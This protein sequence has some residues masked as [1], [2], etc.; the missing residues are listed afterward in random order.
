[1]IKKKGPTAVDKAMHLLAIE[2]NL[3]KN[4]WAFVVAQQEATNNLQSEIKIE[5][6]KKKAKRK[7]SHA[8]SLTTTG[9]DKDGG[10]EGGR[11]KKSQEGG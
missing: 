1:M 10:R 9:V 4:T 7:R 8:T 2:P 3:G 5:E 11:M 6:E